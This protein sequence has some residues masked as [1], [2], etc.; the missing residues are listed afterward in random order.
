MSVA[1]CERGEAARRDWAEMVGPEAMA[2]WVERF[3][4]FASGPA[5]TR[6]AYLDELVDR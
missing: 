5:E 4:L 6:E 1:S 2:V 3:S